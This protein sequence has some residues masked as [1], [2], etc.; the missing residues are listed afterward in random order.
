M[1]ENK[2]QKCGKV[3]ENSELILDHERMDIFRHSCEC[4]QI[5]VY[6]VK[7]RK[8]REKKNGNK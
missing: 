4:G 3:M 8:K 2:C 5:T 1:M 7:H 6:A